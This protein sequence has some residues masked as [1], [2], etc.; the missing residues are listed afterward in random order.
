MKIYNYMEIKESL[1]VH[2]RD[3]LKLMA[4]MAGCGGILFKIY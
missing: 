4:L 1:K 3:Q 2:F